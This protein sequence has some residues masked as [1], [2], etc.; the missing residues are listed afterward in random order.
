MEVA[1]EAAGRREVV[2]L[3]RKNLWAAHFVFPV[4]AGGDGT[5][6][7]LVRAGGERTLMAMASLG[8]QSGSPGRMEAASAGIQ[9]E[10]R[11]FRVAEDGKRTVLAEGAKLQVG[12]VV[13]VE[14]KMTSDDELDFVHLRD[15]LPAGLEPLMQLSGYEDGAYRESRCGET[16]FFISTLSRWNRVQHYQ[17][18]AVTKGAGTALPARAECMYTPEISGQSGRRVI[19]VE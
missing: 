9:V 11:Y 16:D 12:E 14:L 4:E 6:P 8:Y 13:E 18:R 15:P 7:V 10:R 5:F 2:Q 17:L 1:V 19:E 3:D